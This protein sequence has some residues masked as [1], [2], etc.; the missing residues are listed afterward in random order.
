MISRSSASSWASS[1]RRSSAPFAEGD[2]LQ[3]LFFSILFGVSLAMVGDKAKPVTD[4]LQAVTAP[5]F[6]LVAILMKAAPSAPLAPWPSPSAN[7]ALARSPT[8]R[9]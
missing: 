5:M 2:I 9:C 7:T 1:R 4:F 8:W 3:V 6:K